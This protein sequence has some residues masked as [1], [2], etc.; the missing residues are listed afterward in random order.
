MLQAF[1]FFFFSFL[2]STLNR[3]WCWIMLAIN[4]QCVFQSYSDYMREYQR[5]RHSSSLPPMR[6]RIVAVLVS[7]V[8]FA[9]MNFSRLFCML[10]IKTFS[11]FVPF[12]VTFSFASSGSAFLLSSAR[13]PQW[14]TQWLPQN[15]KYLLLTATTVKPVLSGHPVLSDHLSKSRK[16]LPFITLNL[17]SIEQ[18][19]LFNG[20][21]HPFQGPTEVFLL[22]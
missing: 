16:S 18:S 3:L 7:I 17:L 1:F 2:A 6:V 5:S 11:F 13:G 4:Y 22:F 10:W 19:P 12:L 15:C 8:Y 9:G 14:L 20:R 21:S